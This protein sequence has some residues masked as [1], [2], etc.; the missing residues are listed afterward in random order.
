M[1][2]T[3]LGHSQVWRNCFICATWPIHSHVWHDSFMFWKQ[4]YEFWMPSDVWHG[5]HDSLTFWKQSYDKCPWEFCT[6]KTHKC[7]WEFYEYQGIWFAR[8]G[9]FWVCRILNSHWHLCVQ[10]SAHPKSTKS[11]KSNSS[12]QIQNHNLNLNLYGEISRNLSF[13]ISWISGVQ[14]FQWKLSVLSSQNIFS[15]NYHV[16]YQYIESS[17]RHTYQ[18]I[19]NS[20][21]LSEHEWVMS[22]ISVHPEL[23]VSHIS[24]LPELCTWALDALICVT[25]LT[26]IIH[27]YD[28]ARCYVWHHSFPTHS[29]AWHSSRGYGVASTSRLLQIIGLFC[30]ISSLL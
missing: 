17:P 19:Q 25:R 10:N 7:R 15:G 14:H 12:V 3:R 21:L 30:E 13:S 8:F 4:S 9:G 29:Y 26:W 2:V 16:A 24:M 1:C 18:C 20:W 6:P 27:M 23:T 22:Y 5:W 11:S 28:M